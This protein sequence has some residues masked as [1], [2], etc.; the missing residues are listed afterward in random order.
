MRAGDLDRW[1]RIERAVAG[2]RSASGQPTKTWVLQAE[3]W[4]E[5][6]ENRGQELFASN[7]KAAKAEVM[8]RIRYPETMTPQPS[9]SEDC[10]IVYD[11]ISYEIVSTPEGR[12]RH[13]EMLLFCTARAEKAA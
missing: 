8:F 7:A 5:K 10:R 2:P 3:V 6:I 12:G 9:P 1:I 13:E 11:G 4:A